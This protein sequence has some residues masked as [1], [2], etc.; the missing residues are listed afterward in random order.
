MTEI[1]TTDIGSALER[2][3]LAGS[4]KVPL[5]LGL[6][7]LGKSHQ[8][9]DF[10][11]KFGLHY[12]DYRCAYKTFNDVRGYGTPNFETRR[13]E[14][15]RDEDLDIVGNARNFI[16]F[17][18][19]LLANPN[20]QKVLMQLILD[21]QV[22]KFK[23]PADTFMCASSNRLTH[24]ADVSRMNSAL[25]D[26]FAIYWIRP[27]FESFKN[28]LS[29]VGASLVLAYVQSNPTAPYDFDLGD[30]DGESSFPSFRSI[31]QLQ[32]L[33]DSYN[34]LD[35]MASDPL[36]TQHCSSYV[37]GKHGAMFAQFVKIVKEV[38]SIDQM[39]EEADTCDIPSA[40]DMKWIIA[41]KL[42]S[43]ANRHNLEAVL[44]LS[45]RLVDSTGK[46]WNTLTNPN[47]MQTFV[48]NGIKNDRAD[49]CRRPEISKWIAKFNHILTA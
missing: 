32:K 10:S 45:H 25:A 17:E 12:I 42:I 4:S 30:W 47:S 8:A 33:V 23:L 1:T 48:M 22:G 31:E 27:D 34:S 13:M 9:R 40:P 15:L 20:T 14:F 26:R 21:K 2:N 18:E 11:K 44:T 38:G 49:L 16:H 37:G 19:V 6:F 5:F 35:E 7:G 24:K 39:L 3:L 29:S 28:H 46:K 43:A 36:L 41:C